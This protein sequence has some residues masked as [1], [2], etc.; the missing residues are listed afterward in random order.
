MTRHPRRLRAESGAVTLEGAIMAPV[1]ILAT[2]IIV[3][4]ACYFM[5]NTTATNAAQISAEM[6]R[7]RGATDTDGVQAGRD[8][9]AD[10]DAMSQATISVTRSG[11]RVTATVTAPAPSIV[12]IVPMP[13]V[14]SEINVPVERV[15]RQ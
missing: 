13:D 5:A 12:P 8:Y 11:G 14:R 9:L 6:A 10:I 2:M 15:T 4:A 3:Q 7:V 1:V